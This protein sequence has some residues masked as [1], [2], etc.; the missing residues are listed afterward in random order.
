MVVR[1]KDETQK[2]CVKT[3]RN[4]GFMPQNIADCGYRYEVKDWVDASN[5]WFPTLSAK[6]PKGWGTGIYSAVM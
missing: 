4:S 6:A 3:G 5:S 1:A 2:S